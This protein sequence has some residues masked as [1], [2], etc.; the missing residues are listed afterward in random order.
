MGELSFQTGQFRR[1][2]QE[3]RLGLLDLLVLHSVVPV[4]RDNWNLQRQ[5]TIQVDIPLQEIQSL[6]KMLDIIGFMVHL[7]LI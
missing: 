7:V 5:N 6:F 3:E 2:Q 1:V 4:V